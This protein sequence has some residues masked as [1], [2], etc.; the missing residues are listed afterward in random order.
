MCLSVQHST[1][2]VGV[3]CVSHCA[4]ATLHS[5][6]ISTFHMTHW[7]FVS[8]Y[9]FKKPC[10]AL[11]A[12]SQQTAIYLSK[13]THW[14]NIF[15]GLPIFLK[16]P[17]PLPLFIAG[18]VCRPAELVPAIWKYCYLVLRG[19]YHQ[20][21]LCANVKHTATCK[22]TSQLVHACVCSRGHCG[23]PAGHMHFCCPPSYC[24]ATEN[25]ENTSDLTFWWNSTH[26]NLY[27]WH[28]GPGWLN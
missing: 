19:N 13:L 14:P 1:A 4:S 26:K 17:G 22:D 15:L 16:S 6:K 11:D 27:R 25:T 5:G 23:R 7:I 20:D 8:A 24:P 28:V 3:W 12:R 18:L 10:T 21:V 2:E 9:I